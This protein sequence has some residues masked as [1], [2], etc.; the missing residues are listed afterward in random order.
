M[1]STTQK[2]NYHALEGIGPNPRWLP[3]VF[4]FG[5]CSCVHFV[6]LS[7][8]LIYVSLWILRH[9]CLSWTVI[10]ISEGVVSISQFCTCKVPIKLQNCSSISAEFNY[11]Q[12]RELFIEMCVLNKLV[13]AFSCYPVEQSS[14]LVKETVVA[15]VFFHPSS[16]RELV[17]LL[18]YL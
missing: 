9:V 17:S 1:Q 10:F 4:V 6:W 15:L 11:R 7:V 13:I 18:C 12:N 16:E 5:F 2:L 14:P 3:D 8:L